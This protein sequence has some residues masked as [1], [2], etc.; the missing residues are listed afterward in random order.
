[1]FT[2]RQ[3]DLKIPEPDAAVQ[4]I[5]IDPMGTM[6]AAVNNKVCMIVLQWV[7]LDFVMPLPDLQGCG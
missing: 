2:Q 5:S 3:Y 1:M 4:S 7:A 6:M